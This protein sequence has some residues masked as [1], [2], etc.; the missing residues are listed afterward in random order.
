VRGP[1]PPLITVSAVTSHQPPRTWHRFG[2]GDPKGGGAVYRRR[3]HALMS[4]AAR[5]RRA[6]VT[7]RFPF[8]QPNCHS[9]SNGLVAGPATRGSA[10]WL[11]LSRFSRRWHVVVMDE[12]RPNRSDVAL[13]VAAQTDP[14]AFGEFYRRHAIGVERWLRTQTPDLATA[15][16]LTAETFAQALVSLRRFRGSTDEQ[17]VGWLFG[18]ARNLV[19]RFYRRGRAELQMCRRLG[20]QL[21]HDAD[22]LARLEAQIDARAQA[23]ELSDALSTLPD[24]QRQALQ[25]RVIDELDYHEAAALMGTSEQNARIRVSRALKTLSLRLQGVHR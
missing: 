24:A 4:T 15:A 2:I 25:L 1:P 18:I 20:I 8:D 19:R 23:S 11:G 12:P 14:D 3:P 16:D 7:A 13:L 6:A 5:R 10:W 22:E 9:R 21:G 17:A